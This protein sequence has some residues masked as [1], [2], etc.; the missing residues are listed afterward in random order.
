MYYIGIDLGGTNISAGLVNEKGEIL[1]RDSRLTLKERGY[2]AIV[3]DMA[4]IC[5]DFIKKMNINVEDVHSIGIGSPGVPD[6]EAGILLYSNNLNFRNVPL[7]DE[8]K[9]YFDLP[10]FI[11]NDANCAAFGESISGAAADYTDSITVTLGTGI[12][13][14][15]IIN[16]SIFNGSFYGGG[17]VGHMVIKADGETC[18]CGRKGCWEAYASATALIRETRIAAAKYPNSE[19]FSLVNGDIKLIDAKVPFDAAEKGDEIAAEII[20]NYIRYLAVG[21]TNLINIFQPHAIVI[22]GGVC[23]Q[24]NKIIEPLTKYVK[25]RVYGGIL[26]TKIVTAKLGNDAGIV[27]AAFLSKN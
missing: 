18:T 11:E 5:A 12:G 10:V 13:S 17:E 7:R 3:K 9:K 8:L 23:A 16:G 4:S 15:I 24:G 25:S 14:G 20:N 6:T 2:E 21:I 1:L 19:I 27:G 22:G 26:K